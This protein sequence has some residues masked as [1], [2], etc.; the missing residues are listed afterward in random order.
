MG[1]YYNTQKKTK[2]GYLICVVPMCQ[3]KKST[4]TLKT[5]EFPSD[6]KRR[7]QWISAIVEATLRNEEKSS[8]EDLYALENRRMELEMEISSALGDHSY[9]CARHF[10]PEDIVVHPNVCRLTSNAVPSIFSNYSTDLPRQFFKKVCQTARSI[11]SIEE[12]P[13]SLIREETE[14][15]EYDEELQDSINYFQEVVYEPIVISED[16]NIRGIPEFCTTGID[17]SSSI[18][19][20]SISENPDMSRPVYVV[21]RGTNT[22]I[23]YTGVSNTKLIKN[24][25]R[26]KLRLME[27]RYKNVKKRLTELENKHVLYNLESLEKDAENDNEEAKFILEMLRSYNAF[28][29]TRKEIL[30][31]QKAANDNDDI[32][33]EHSPTK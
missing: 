1:K 6:L 4:T 25:L 13:L 20:E 15:N 10:L 19:Y 5:F 28:E 7:N 11:V 12:D 16:V 27:S 9:V 22:K 21:S 2:S 17:G 29:D 8:L 26:K 18:D 3:T 24:K 30:T 31:S 23:K 33:Y 32:A 14:R